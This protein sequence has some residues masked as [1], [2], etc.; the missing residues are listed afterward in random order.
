[1]REP[2]PKPAPRIDE[3]LRDMRA[4]PIVPRKNESCCDCLCKVLGKIGYNGFFMFFYIFA[5]IMLAFLELILF[6]FDVIITGLALCCKRGYHFELG[7]MNGKATC[8]LML[9]NKD[10]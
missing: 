7:K 6:P 1:M 9:L 4:P 8:K 2:P 5:L 10:L 3:G